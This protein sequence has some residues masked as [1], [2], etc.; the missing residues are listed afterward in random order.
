L[1]DLEKILKMVKILLKLWKVEVPKMII[2]I[3]SQPDVTIV[4]LKAFARKII[5][6]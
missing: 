3:V 6:A 2:L 5:I 4:V 1:K